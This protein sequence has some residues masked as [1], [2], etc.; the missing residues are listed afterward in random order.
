MKTSVARLLGV[1][2]LAGAHRIGLHPGPAAGSAPSRDFHTRGCFGPGHP[3][4]KL[5][6]LMS[7][8]PHPPHPKRERLKES[9]S[10]IYR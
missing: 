9:L 10:P 6:G 2:E 3:S 8:L 5:L 7:I 4:V 1:G